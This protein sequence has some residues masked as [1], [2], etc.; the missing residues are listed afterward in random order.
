[1]TS[2]PQTLV[3]ANRNQDSSWTLK[4]NIAS[5]LGFINSLITSLN[6]MGLNLGVQ[7][8]MNRGNQGNIINHIESRIGT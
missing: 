8:G 5:Q 2:Q 3:A 4:G 7:P 1:M 6:T